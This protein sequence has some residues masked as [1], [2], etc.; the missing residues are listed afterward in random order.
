MAAFAFL[1]FLAAAVFLVLALRWLLVLRRCAIEA[2]LPLTP[3]DKALAAGPIGY[4]LFC[5]IAAGVLGDH[6]AD[7]LA[8][9]STTTT[10]PLF[11]TLSEGTAVWVVGLLAGL[12]VATPPIVVFTVEWHF[13]RR[14]PELVALGRRAV[15]AIASGARAGAPPAPAAPA[16]D[17]EDAR[18]K[19]LLH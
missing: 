6:I 15:W 7:I 3:L 4:T 17:S 18:W 5:F 1:G 8:E 14:L 12:A 9:G 11:G 19:K 2:R 16:V 10:L 13:A